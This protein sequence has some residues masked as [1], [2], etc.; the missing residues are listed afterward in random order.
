[1]L[2]LD[3]FERLCSR[4]TLKDRDSGDMVPFLFNPS[5]QKIMQKVR[6]HQKKGRHLWLIF[7]KA[8]RL[9]IS[10]WT[11]GL[12]LAHCMQKV[13]AHA[14]VVGQLTETGKEMFD[15]V[16][17]FADQLP[18]RLPARTQ[19]EML[20]PHSG[21]VSK[22]S[23]ATAK[24]VIGGRGMT[25]SFLHLTEA[26]FYPGEASFVALLNTVS[27]AD[28]DNIVIIETTANG[29]EGDGAAYYNYWKAAEAEQNEF[30]SIF[31]PWWEDP[32][33][34]LPDK[35]APDAPA[36]DYEKWLMREFKC[37]RGQIAWF[38]STLET[39]C[40]GSIYT[41]K[42]EYP[43]TPDEAFVASGEPIFD[44]EELEYMRKSCVD[45]EEKG[46][47]LG[48][49][50]RM[51]LQPDGP[52]YIWEQP[53]D[54]DHY[55][56][57]VDAAKGVEEGDFAS[58]V[59][60]NAETGKQ[61]FTY[62]AKIGPERLA[63]VV[64]FLARRYNKAMV[65]VELTG[66]WGY[67]TMKDLRDKYHYPNQYLWRSRDDKPDTKPRQAFGWETTERSRQMLYTVFR[68]AVRSSLPRDYGDG[69][70]VSTPEVVVRDIRLYSQASRAQSDIGFRW[71]V[72][73]GHD[74]ILM[75]AWLGFVA[76]CHY[77]TPHPDFRTVH[78]LMKD[79]EPR[80]PFTYDDSPEATADGVIG[81]YSNDHLKRVLNF[82]KNRAMHAEKRLEGI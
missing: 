10:R 24:T 77:H 62:A 4:L 37:T 18:M 64:H 78:N 76:L 8:R 54:C 82:G 57:G 65:N 69:K 71:R 50:P 73:K 30:L 43:A 63:E 56:I 27:A 35:Y 44:F 79:Q 2:S 13:N 51:V 3:H 61:A 80:L 9:G 67:Q 46:D 55:Y 19:R 33:T 52:L 22:F 5:Q 58:A 74:D 20:I 23:R 72:L 70:L 47:I 32:A 28:P 21:G 38:R 17:Q 81:I 60:W 66:G 75:A 49:H 12:A 41:W 16:G 45:P 15:Q 68:K 7:L 53:H 1:M 36:D 11:A 34:R 39:K 31:L 6:R 25:H 59:G 42:Q 40:G 29:M 26:A 14:R 48:S